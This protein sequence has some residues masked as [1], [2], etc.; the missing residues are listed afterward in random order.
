MSAELINSIFKQHFN[1][2]GGNINDRPRIFREHNT[3]I[4]NSSVDNFIPDSL[5]SGKGERKMKYK[6]IYM[7]FN[8][9]EDDCGMEVHEIEA[10]DYNSAY[11]LA[12]EYPG[13]LYK[14]KIEVECDECDGEGTFEASDCCGARII[15]GG[16]DKICKYCYEHC[17]KEVCEKCNGTWKYFE[18]IKP[19]LKNAG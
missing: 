11:A 4:P 5:Q 15:G 9:E 10:V 17:S 2:N 7:H 1:F 8:G 16:D 19:E 14:M 12:K 18:E 3:P 13:T 6:A